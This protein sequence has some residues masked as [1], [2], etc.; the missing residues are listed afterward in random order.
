MI[1]V[2]PHIVSS[3][4]RP[5]IVPRIIRLG[6]VVGIVVNVHLRINHAGIIR[7]GRVLH[8]SVNSIVWAV[9]AFVMRRA[10]NH[11]T[12][13][14][15]INQIAR[16]QIATN[17]G[18][19]H[20]VGVACRL[21][22]DIGR[23]NFCVGDG[24]DY[25]IG[26]GVVRAIAVRHRDANLPVVGIIIFA[27]HDVAS[28]VIKGFG[29]IVRVYRIQAQQKGGIRIG[30]KR[31]VVIALVIAARYAAVGSARRPV[32]NDIVPDIERAS[33]MNAFVI[34]AR[35]GPTAVG[36]MCDQVMMVAADFAADGG[37]ECVRLKTIGA[38][39]VGFAGSGPFQIVVVVGII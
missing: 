38:A 8:K 23:K 17:I 1:R 35:Q 37:C 36:R 11:F 33:I 24:H 19:H 29:R 21:G 7:T 9:G 20:F 27:L 16:G 14:A 4:R 12:D 25:L 2:R 3:V 26:R 10:V 22:R 13:D 30:W 39:I 34:A 18:Q 32:V 6:D 15:L 31:L 5:R 28:H